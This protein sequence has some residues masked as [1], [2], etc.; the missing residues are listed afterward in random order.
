MKKVGVFVLLVILVAGLWLISRQF[1]EAK[2]AAAKSA[3]SAVTVFEVIPDLTGLLLHGVGYGPYQGNQSPSC[4]PLP[5]REQIAGDL[6]YLAKRLKLIRIYSVLPPVGPM[7]MEEAQKAGLEV[8]AGCW[9]GEDKVLNQ[10]ELDALI[11]TAKKYRLKRI[12]IGNEVLLRGDLTEDELISLIKQARKATDIE[13][14]YADIYAVLKQSPRVVEACDFVL[15]HIYGYWDGIA[16]ETAAKYAIDRYDELQRRYRDKEL[17]IGETGWPKA[18]ETNGEAVPSVD[19][20]AKYCREFVKLAN[21]RKI[22]YYYFEAFDEPWKV[23]QEGGV[24]ASWGIYPRGQTVEVVKIDQFPFT[25]YDEPDS[26]SHFAASGWM[27]D[28]RSIHLDVYCQDNPHSGRYCTK[29]TYLGGPNLWAGV[30][31]Q[32]PEDNWGD[33][34]G[35][36]FIGVSKLTFWA[37]G[38]KGKEQVTFKIGG[39]GSADKK[40]SDTLQDKSISVGLSKNWQKYEIK[41]GEQD[42]ACVISGF[43]LVTSGLINNKL[44]IQIYLD[45]IQFE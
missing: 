8:L 34:P 19:N 27:G 35:Y 25:V 32:F 18:G 7:I 5:T 12:V 1:G 3:S 22:P 40:Y 16:V 14:G 45:D 4:G 43:C 11:S 36:Q 38:E 24:G 20:Q 41:L 15:V 21:E 2:L 17:I 33:L 13:V 31:W 9:L 29:Y 28:L 30:Y 37:R 42:P 44:P 10:K 26:I 23:V 6:D 39:I